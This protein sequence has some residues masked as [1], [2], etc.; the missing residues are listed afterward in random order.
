MTEQNH[1]PANSEHQLFQ[2]LKSLVIEKQREERQLR[3]LKRN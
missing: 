1:K 3:K 2:I